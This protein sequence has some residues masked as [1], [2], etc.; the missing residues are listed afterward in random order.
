[1]IFIYSNPHS[2]L[3]CFAW[4]FEYPIHI[5]ERYSQDFFFFLEVWSNVLE[6][7]IKFILGEIFG[8][9]F[10]M[11]RWLVKGKTFGARFGGI[12]RAKSGG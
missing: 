3:V 7:K 4:D 5:E 12:S 9:F 2:F 8:M 11:E 10:F 1:M 6:R